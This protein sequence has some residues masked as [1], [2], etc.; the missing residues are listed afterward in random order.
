MEFLFNYLKNGEQVNSRWSTLQMT[1]LSIFFNLSM[2]I[3]FSSIILTW[4]SELFPSDYHLLV[5]VSS[6]EIFHRMLA[7]YVFGR[8][9][10]NCLRVTDAEEEKNTH[11]A[12]N[13]LHRN[14]PIIFILG[15]NL[16]AQLAKF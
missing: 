5:I 12:A 4:R 16:H 11:I 1:A 3:H 6:F 15:K 14:I 9:L 8:L 7:I 13:E 10:L 2:L